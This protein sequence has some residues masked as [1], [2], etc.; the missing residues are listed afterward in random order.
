MCSDRWVNNVCSDRYRSTWCVQ[1]EN[2]LTRRVQTN[3]IMGQQG[4]FRQMSQQGVFRHE[5]ALEY[6]KARANTI[7]RD[8][9]QVHECQ[10]KLVSWFDIEV[11]VAL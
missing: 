4:V 5:Y 9:G 1:K 2:K 6:L 8:V 11:V 10:Y 3:N 7:R